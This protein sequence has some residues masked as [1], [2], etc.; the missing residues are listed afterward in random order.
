MKKH[1]IDL[2][3]D[4]TMSELDKEFHEKFMGIEHYKIG[5][6]FGFILSQLDDEAQKKFG[7]FIQLM[8]SFGI[9]AEKNNHVERFK[10][11]PLEE[12]EEKK[13]KENYFG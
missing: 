4:G 9:W 8:V 2:K 5:F 3:F 10:R 7:H 6:D 12:K 11:V 1:Y 13:T